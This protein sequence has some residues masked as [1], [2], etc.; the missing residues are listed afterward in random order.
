M[1]H[2]VGVGFLAGLMFLAGLSSGGRAE[3]APQSQVLFAQLQENPQ[4]Y[5]GASVVLGGEIVRLTPSAQG[6]LLQVLQHPLDSGL[7]PDP[8]AFSGGWFWVEYSEEAGPL[9]FLTPLIT[10]V[11]EV[12]GTRQGFP[13]V[14]AQK[15]FLA[16]SMFSLSS[17]PMAY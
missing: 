12:I 1:R 14:R 11:G 9:S 4:A 15:A 2:G 16:P 8:L 13:L 17:S 10:V 7:A 5:L 6:F 3:Q